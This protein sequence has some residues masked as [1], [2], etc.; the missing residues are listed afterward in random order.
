MLSLNF[1]RQ[2]S[3]ISRWCWFRIEHKIISPEKSFITTRVCWN[4]PSS[5]DNFYAIRIH[6][7]LQIQQFARFLYSKFLKQTLIFLIF[8]VLLLSLCC[9][10][11]VPQ[12]I[13]SAYKMFLW[14]HYSLD[15]TS[16]VITHAGDCVLSL[17]E[18]C[19]IRQILG[20]LQ[21]H[22]FNTEIWLLQLKCFWV[23]PTQFMDAQSF[24]Y[25]LAGLRLPQENGVN[26]SITRRLPLPNCQGRRGR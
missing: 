4:I 2:N 23:L 14:R 25:K 6:L 8:S 17:F 16:K 9:A 26:R 12:K 18:S 5:A 13:F 15:S 22:A 7:S 24:M 21:T 1:F 11:T 3:H 10:S 20:V 19:F